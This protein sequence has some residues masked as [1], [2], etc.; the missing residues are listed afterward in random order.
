MPI[1]INCTSYHREGKCAHP[2]APRGFF[3][4]VCIIWARETRIADGVEFDRRVPEGCALC[5]PHKKPGLVPSKP[6]DLPNP[7]MPLRG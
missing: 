7:F 2:C 3:K 4:P 1:N 6:S 5:T